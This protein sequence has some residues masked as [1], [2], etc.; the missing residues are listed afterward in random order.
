MRHGTQTQINDSHTSPEALTMTNGA[1]RGVVGGCCCCSCCLQPE[2][3]QKGA[4]QLK[5]KWIR[6][7]R[8]DEIDSCCFYAL[9]VRGLLLLLLLQAHYYQR[10]CCHKSFAMFCTF[11]PTRQSNRSSCVALVGERV[12]LATWLNRIALK[13]DRQQQRCPAGTKA[14]TE[15]AKLWRGGKRGATKWG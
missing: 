15:Q 12:A 11:P 9:L 8:K 1:G 13:G 4:A 10:C 3:Q 2:I 6:K 5:S 14:P 7:C